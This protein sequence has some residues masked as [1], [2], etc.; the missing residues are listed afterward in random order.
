MRF[1]YLVKHDGKFYKPGEDVPIEEPKNQIV[2]PQPVED[3]AAADTMDT[4]KRRG[5]K[6]LH[7]DE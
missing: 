4:P 1:A 6:P 7:A 5:R 3:A 2:E